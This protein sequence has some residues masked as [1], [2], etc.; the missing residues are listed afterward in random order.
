MDERVSVA[1][2]TDV[3][4]E[5]ADGS[6]LEARLAEARAL[7]ASLAVLPELPLN[8]WSPATRVPRDEDAE[9]PA[10]PRQ[11]AMAEAVAKVGVALLGG[12]I[13]TDPDTG[14][15][16]NTA[17]LYDARGLELGQY[18][19][20]H[21]PEEEGYWETSHYVPG[22]EPPRAMPGPGISVGVQI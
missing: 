18:R 7:G 6:R 5:G 20:V 1:L 3:F 13:V 16:H 14:Q 11:R 19:K 15:R 17:I 8:P 9:P 21:L 12:A 4:H 2:I 22:M 10:G